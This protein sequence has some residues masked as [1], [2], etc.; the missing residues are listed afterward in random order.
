MDTHNIIERLTEQEYNLVV[1]EGTYK[2]RESVLL[3]T[4]HP[5]PS[6]APSQPPN[7]LDTSKKPPTS[8]TQLSLAILGPKGAALALQLKQQLY[9]NTRP[10]TPDSEESPLSTHETN[11]QTEVKSNSR[12]SDYN[13]SNNKEPLSDIDA[14]TAAPIFGQ[15][16]P[17][18]ASNTAAKDTK[19]GAKKKKPKNGMIKTNSSFISRVHPMDGLT[20]KLNERDQDGVL[21]F[22]N[23]NRAFLWL[24]ISNL[25]KTKVSLSSPNELHRV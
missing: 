19:E 16:N 8:G 12:S 21:A 10:A 18:L 4:P 15:D 24:D 1:G 14:S 2:L 22:A 13:G 17:A 20:K 11:S 7:P 25:Q 6:E 3:A 9:L 23:I 5:H